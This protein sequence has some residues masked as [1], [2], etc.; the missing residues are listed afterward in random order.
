MVEVGL[1]LFMSEHIVCSL[2]QDIHEEYPALSQIGGVVPPLP[3]CI[4]GWNGM[5]RGIVNQWAATNSPSCA[6]LGDEG[7]TWRRL[8][9]IVSS[10]MR[11]LVTLL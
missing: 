8:R 7:R 6:P 9:S 3:Q 2:P 1:G 11:L 5:L 10:A 4:H